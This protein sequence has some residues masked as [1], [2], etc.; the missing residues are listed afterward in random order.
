LR[1]GAIGRTDDEDGAQDPGPVVG[2]LPGG[3]EY[4]VIHLRQVLPVSGKIFASQRGG[5]GFVSAVDDPEH[6]FF[7]ERGTWRAAI[8]RTRGHDRPPP[9]TALPFS[10]CEG[11]RRASDRHAP[12]HT[13]WK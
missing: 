6:C 1:A 5:I 4:L 7:L 2:I 12:A 9:Q 3:K 13:L 11:W 8:L 10:P